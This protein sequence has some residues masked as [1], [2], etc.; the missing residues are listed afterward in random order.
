MIG[1]DMVN[2]K[3]FLRQPKLIDIKI[4]NKLAEKE[5]W[6][7][8]AFGI[9]ANNDSERVQSSGSKQKMADAVGKYVDIERQIDE[10]IDKLIDAKKDVL[11]VIEQLEPNEYDVT[12]KRYIQDMTFDEIAFVYKKSKSWATTIH[13]NALQSVQKILDERE[14]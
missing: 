13:G 6:K 7:S 4:Q 8:I 9:S 10:T 3:E 14:K 1:G 5:R 12:H 2:A 11:S